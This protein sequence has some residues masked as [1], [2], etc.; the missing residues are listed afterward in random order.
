VK[1]QHQ[2]IFKKFKGL[3]KK[4]WMMYYGTSLSVLGG[5]SSTPLRSMLS[6]CVESHE[7]GK[8]FTLSSVASSLASLV[9][10]VVIQEM[11]EY[12][13]DTFPGAIYIFHGSIELVAVGMMSIVYVWIRRHE[14]LN[15]PLGHSNS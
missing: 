6:K 10:S 9:S 7:Y 1:L 15:G 3:S 11:Y 13:L 8:I 5:M 2:E 14:R 4:G 12:T